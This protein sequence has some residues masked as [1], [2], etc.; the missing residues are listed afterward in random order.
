MIDKSLIKGEN[1]IAKLLNNLTQ[2]LLAIK[3]AAAYINK[4]T[5]SV[6]NYLGLY[7]ANNE[8]LIHLLST[9]FE[10]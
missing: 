8:N 1:V 7:K 9:E 6:F 10:D 3:Q 2:L 4:N 5:K